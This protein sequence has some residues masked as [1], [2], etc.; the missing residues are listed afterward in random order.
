MIQHVDGHLERIES[1]RSIAKNT[2]KNAFINQESALSL[3]GG[4][5]VIKGLVIRFINH[6]LND[7]KSQLTLMT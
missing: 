6:V 2:H 1:Q 4:A 5:F 7:E 3:Y